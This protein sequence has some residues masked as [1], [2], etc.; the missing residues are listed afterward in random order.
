MKK[1]TP[2]VIE[3]IIVSELDPDWYPK[4]A[5][6]K[7]GSV[8]LFKLVRKTVQTK[9]GNGWTYDF[10]LTNE[11]GMPLAELGTIFVIPCRYKSHDGYDV[12]WM[13]KDRSSI[14]LSNLNLENKKGHAQWHSF[15]ASTAFDIARSIAEY[16]GEYDEENTHHDRS[17]M[18][19]DAYYASAEMKDGYED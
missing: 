13:H 8:V 3:K 5:I 10:N 4:K 16:Q 14:S 9:N 6:M 2:Q 18:K 17:I 7:D 19:F 12:A 15:S 11:D 1:L